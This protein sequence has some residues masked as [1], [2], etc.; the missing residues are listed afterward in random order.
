MID[1][2]KNL[3]G[4]TD[5]PAREVLPSAADHR[6]STFLDAWRASRSDALVPNKRAFNPLDVPSL[7]RFTWLYRYDP[8]AGD[9]V[10]QLAGE[11][12]NRAWGGPIK[13]K[14]LRQVIGEDDHRIVS[15]RWH[16][17]IDT[18]LVQY[19]ARNE[20]LSSQDLWRAERLLLPLT[21]TG[22]KPDHVI[23]V[24]LYRL[25]GRETAHAPLNVEDIRQVHC[26]D[27]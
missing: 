27:I 15:P 14:T 4:G 21:S 19:G 17:I 23:G 26:A 18:P 6:L 8:A 20:K 16:A 7:L 1:M 2:N 22:D 25:A 10:C 5:R 3:A 9:F 12:V 13:S 11:D 24:S